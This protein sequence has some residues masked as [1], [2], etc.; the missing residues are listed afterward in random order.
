LLG[1]GLAYIEPRH[2]LGLVTEAFMARVLRARHSFRTHLPSH[3]SGEIEF[4]DPAS[5][6][7]AAPVG[8]NILFGRISY[9]IANAP[10]RV[11]ALA[12]AVV[13]E[14]GLDKDIFALGLNFEVGKNGWQLQPAQ[15]ARIAIA[16][17]LVANPQILVMENALLAFSSTEAEELLHSVRSAMQGRTLIAT[18]PSSGQA[19][20]FDRIIEFEGSRIVT[21]D[22]VTLAQSA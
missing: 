3:Y 18:L 12:R 21:R 13:E 20:G 11:Y 10:E 2:R 5:Y 9:G 15:R 7:R 14:L 6:M 1:A 4:Y 19:E 8:D 17:A 22:I 16:R